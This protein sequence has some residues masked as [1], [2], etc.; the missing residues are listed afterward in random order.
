MS[1]TSECGQST[2]P[3]YPRLVFSNFVAMLRLLARE[4][5]LKGVENTLF[6]GESSLQD[7][8]D[9]L[10]EFED[11]ITAEEGAAII[12]RLDAGKLDEA[13]AGKVSV[14]LLSLGCGSEGLNLCAASC[15]VLFDPWWQ[16]TTEEQAVSRA[17]R[18]G[19]KHTS[20]KVF[21]F[22]SAK[23]IEQYM[24]DTQEGKHADARDFLLGSTPGPSQ[25]G[26][27][28]STTVVRRLLDFDG[29]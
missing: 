7:R 22:I 4:L 11:P 12:A 9:I 8:K 20:V 29:T 6:T 24:V 27:L 25:S 28:L 3:A 21:R 2:H 1:A 23:T 26:R 17:H 5:D 19:Q 18:L 15:V 16:P 10:D 14:L 13:C